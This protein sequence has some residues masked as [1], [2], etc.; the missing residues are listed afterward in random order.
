[1][2]AA[3]VIS[4]IAVAA[5]SGADD[6]AGNGGTAMRG[7]AKDLPQNFR[8][9]VL[10]TNDVI[11][12]KMFRRARQFP[13]RGHLRCQKLRLTQRCQ[14]PSLPCECGPS[15]TQA[16][17]P[18]RA[19]IGVAWPLS[20]KRQDLWPAL[21]RPSPM[22]GWEAWTLI[23][24]RSRGISRSVPPGWLAERVRSVCAPAGGRV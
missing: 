4:R 20:P 2:L 6:H 16:G 14:H 18:E 22:T 24:A 7:S 17:T 19:T 9:P 23:S 21:R 12:T 1:M 10:R 8:Y 15:I 11:V 3:T 13:L 5:R